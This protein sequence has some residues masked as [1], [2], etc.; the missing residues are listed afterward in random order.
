MFHARTKHIEVDFHFDREK[1]DLLALEVRP[2]ASGDRIVD[3]FTKP[4]TKQML[5]RF[6]PNL[7][8]VATG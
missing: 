8:L 1:V 4:A 5:D 6:K 2:I 3:I 7:N